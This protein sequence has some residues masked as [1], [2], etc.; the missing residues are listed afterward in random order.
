MAKERL[1]ILEDIK[2]RY[3]SSQRSENNGADQLRGYRVTDLRVCFCICKGYQNVSSSLC[4]L[5]MKFILLINVKI[6]NI[7]VD[8]LTFI[9]RIRII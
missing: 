2:G 8:I 4:H 5:S 9:S 1:E 7:F 6:A 3:Y